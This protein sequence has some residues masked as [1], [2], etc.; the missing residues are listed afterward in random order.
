MRTTNYT[1]CQIT[2][3]LL[4]YSLY[5]GIDAY[6]DA[7]IASA[8]QFGLKPRW[9]L[10]SK[11]IVRVLF[12]ISQQPTP[13]AAIYIKYVRFKGALLKQ[14]VRSKLVIVVGVMP[15]RYMITDKGMELINILIN[16]LKDDYYQD[17]ELIGSRVWKKSGITDQKI[18]K[19]LHKSITI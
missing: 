13:E 14:L 5:T 19:A 18:E 17:R 8:A 7:Y 4:L 10:L 15:P 1:F 3:K 16:S 9:T 11:D 2:V 6:Q 12:Y